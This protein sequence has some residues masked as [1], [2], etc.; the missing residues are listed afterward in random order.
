MGKG[1][2]MELLCLGDIALADEKLRKVRWPYPAG[3]QSSETRVLLNWELPAAQ[4][5]NPHPRT[6]GDRLIAFPDAPVLLKSW[7][8]GFASLA[9]NHILDGGIEGLAQTLDQLKQAGFL[10]VGAGLTQEE[11]TAPLVWETSEGRLTILNWVFAE[12]NPD[13]KAIP[14][15]NCWPGVNEAKQTIQALKQQTD[16]LLTLV[17]WSDEAFSYPRPEDRAIARELLQAGADLV[18]GHHPHVVRGMEL[19]GESPVYYSIGNFFFSK[20]PAEQSSEPDGFAPR[21]REAL[22]VRITFQRGK[23]PLCQPLSFFQIG[24]ATH[25][26]PFHLAE[27]RMNRVSRPLLLKTAGEYPCWYSAQ[28]LQFNKIGYRLFFRIWQYR[29]KNWLDFF[30]R[31]IRSRYQRLHQASS[32]AGNQD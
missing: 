10:T 24:N 13:W 19:V 16:W 5:R 9:T 23:K 11:I 26:D 4:R 17:H 3:Q 6:S 25:A 1:K 29:P 14:G 30:S 18:V 15:P 31:F 22:G 8:P 32:H 2:K 20:I 27:R 7:A 12:T 28:R 21:N